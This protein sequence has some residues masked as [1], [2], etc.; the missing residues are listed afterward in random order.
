MV[1]VVLV[2]L[3]GARQFPG[4]PFGMKE[5][6]APSEE[7]ASTLLVLLKLGGLLLIPAALF[8]LG[9]RARRESDS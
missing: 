4:D 5:P 9:H 2:A 6:L 1:A 8:Y 3:W 7:L